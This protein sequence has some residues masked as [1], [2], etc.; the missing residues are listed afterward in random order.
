MTMAAARPNRGQFLVKFAGIADRDAAEALRWQ[1]ILIPEA[2][3]MPLGENENYLHDLMGLHVVTT[4]GQALGK[5]AEILLTPANDV[6]LVRGPLGEVLIPATREVIVRVDLPAA[7]MT[8]ALP[9]GL[10]APVDG[11]ADDGDDDGA[12]DPDGVV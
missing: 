5:I 6:Y 10:L 12:G 2:A 9:D 11:D 7:T 8:V 3:A 4:A 1:Y